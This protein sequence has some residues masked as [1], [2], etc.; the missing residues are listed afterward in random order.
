MKPFSDDQ[1]MLDIHEAMGDA[2]GRL[3]ALTVLRWAP[4]LFAVPIDPLKVRVLLAPGEMGPYNRHRAWCYANASGTEATILINRHLCH[5]S[6]GGVVLGQQQVV[7]DVLIH[8][9][10]HMRQHQLL[11]TGIKRNASRGDHRDKAWYQAVSE[12]CPRYLGHDLP[13]SAWPSSQRAGALRRLRSGALSEVDMTHWPYS[14][15]ALVQAG[16][17]RLPLVATI[18]AA[19]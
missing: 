13:R 4:T 15:R 17:P 16:D 3:C 5:L 12:A 10:T 14:L 6:H 7:E 8:E 9:L 19:A 11:L 18:S 1:H 2:S